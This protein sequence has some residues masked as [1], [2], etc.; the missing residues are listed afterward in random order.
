MCADLEEWRGGTQPKPK[1]TI[2][3]KIPKRHTGKSVIILKP[4]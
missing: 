1:R 3:S 4:R 2:E